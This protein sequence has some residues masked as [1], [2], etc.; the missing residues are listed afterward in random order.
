MDWLDRLMVVDLPPMV[1]LGRL[2]IDLC[3]VLVD[4]N[5]VSDYHVRFRGHA[6]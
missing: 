5:D 2:G 4:Y 1:L 3:L 6:Y